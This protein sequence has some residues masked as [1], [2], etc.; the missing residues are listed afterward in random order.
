MDQERPALAQCKEDTDGKE[1]SAR[2][3][4]EGG[5]GIATRW[6]WGS[7]YLEPRAKRDPRC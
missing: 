7:G 4:R 1:D 3:L 6:W 2:V 5:G